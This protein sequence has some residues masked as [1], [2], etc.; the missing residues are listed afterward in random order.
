MA[1]IQRV[2]ACKSPYC[3]KKAVRRCLYTSSGTALDIKALWDVLNEL[4]DVR[5]KWK[6]IGLGLRLEPSDLDAM[7][8][9]V[10][11]CLQSSLSKWLKGIDPLPTWEALVAVLRSPVVGEE[12]KAQELEE[13]F[14]SGTPILPDTPTP[15][16]G[17]Y[18]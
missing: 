7:S 3:I 2:D 16:K 15:V 9:S 13:K 14:C 5:S 12:K 1:G 6:M 18:A 4:C 11:D 17:V 10:L 8:G